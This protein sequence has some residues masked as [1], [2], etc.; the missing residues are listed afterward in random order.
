MLFRSVTLGNLLS[1]WFLMNRT[2]WTF[3]LVVAFVNMAQFPLGTLMGGFILY[4]LMRPSV[5]ALYAL[6][7]P[8]A[9]AGAGPG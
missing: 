1:G 5:R 8:S 9:D 6:G 7:D 4:T 3:T 2:R